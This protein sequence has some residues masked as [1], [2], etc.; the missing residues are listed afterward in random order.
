L[1]HH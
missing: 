1:K